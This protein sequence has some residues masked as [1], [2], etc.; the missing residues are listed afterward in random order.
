MMVE[1]L[2][3][4]AMATQQPRPRRRPRRPPSPPVLLPPRW[5]EDVAPPPTPFLTSPETS[6]TQLMPPP[7]PP[8]PPMRPAEEG[9]IPSRH[10][11]GHPHHHRRTSK[12]Q[13]QQKRA[14]RSSNN[15][16]VYQNHRYP[17]RWQQ[18]GEAIPAPP[19]AFPNQFEFF[20]HR[21]RNEADSASSLAGAVGSA[22]EVVT[23]AYRFTG[24]SGVDREE[25][26]FGRHYPGGGR[27]GSHNTRRLNRRHSRQSLHAPLPPPPNSQSSSPATTGSS[28]EAVAVAAVSAL[29]APLTTSPASPIE[30]EEP[31]PPLSI[32]RSSS[33]AMGSMKKSVQW[34]SDGKRRPQDISRHDRRLVKNQVDHAQ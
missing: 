33:A 1:H 4:G 31:R 34:V 14:S 19:S 26:P 10:R 5:G 3:R 7:Q 32:L 25:I 23:Y 21:P 12:Q 15:L 2:Q 9:R 20:L 27:L 29:P 13:Q 24:D 11:C 17:E 16:H 22:D 18:W 8:Q 6:P 28:P 30:D